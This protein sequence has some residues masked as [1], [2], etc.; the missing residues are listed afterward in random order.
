MTQSDLALL[1]EMGFEKARDELALKK[2][3][4]CEFPTFVLRASL[5]GEPD[6]S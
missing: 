5:L 4:G 6:I 1:L 3:G 2:S